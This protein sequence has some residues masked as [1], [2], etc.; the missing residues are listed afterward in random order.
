MYAT[1]LKKIIM[2]VG[3]FFQLTTPY[4]C[5]LITPFQ[6]KASSF[7]QSAIELTLFNSV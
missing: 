1:L 5:V 2:Y 6:E 3:H 7:S 4:T